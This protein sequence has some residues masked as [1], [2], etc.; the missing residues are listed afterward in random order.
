MNAITHTFCGNPHENRYAS[1]IFS[2]SLLI[3]LDHGRDLKIEAKKDEFSEK[4]SDF[5]SKTESLLGPADVGPLG[6][7][8]L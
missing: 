3:I 4:L 8:R 1:Q 2:L 6:L 5:S 7:S